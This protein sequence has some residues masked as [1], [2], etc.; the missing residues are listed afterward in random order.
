MH[1]QWVPV[2][3]D[4]E[5]ARRMQMAR[6]VIRAS[7]AAAFALL[8]VVAV[9]WVIT[10]HLSSYYTAAV[11]LV[12]IL[13]SGISL[14][15]LRRQRLNLAI[16]VYTTVL[17]LSLTAATYFLGGITGPVTIG[18]IMT[19]VLIGLTGGTRA[20]RYGGIIIGMIYLIMLLLEAMQVIHPLRV[21]A[22]VSWL[23]EGVL[24]QII[25]IVTAL[26]AGVFINQ[27]GRAF[28]A[29]RQRGFELA[30]AS[31]QAE[32]L[33]IAEREARE[34]E[35]RAALHIR[36]TMAGYVDY[37]SLVAAGEYTARVDVGELEEDVEGDRE[38]HA[39]GEYL[40]ATVDRLVALL[41]ET[42]AV[43]R[44]YTA[45]SWETV[46]EAGR[47]QPGFVYRGNQIAPETEWLPQMLQ[48][49]ERGAS[50][51]QGAG[52]A[53]PLIVNRQV[54]GAIGGQH[55]DGRLWTDEELA[56]IE[57]V[58]GQLAQ[59]IESL[60]LFDETQRRAARERV[61]R[62]VTA[63][64]RSSTDPETV[65]KALLREVGAVL[66]RATFVR[67]LAPGD[68]A[69]LTPSDAAAPDGN[70]AREGGL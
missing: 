40:N 36:E 61:L 63:R 10:P 13:F 70:A 47:V 31:R 45:Q 59:T 22:T 11:A 29:E 48:A 53:A 4:Q 43:Q 50:V 12:F 58:T 23:I 52:G 15:L 68:S 35:T 3:M 62:E 64:V 25:F 37:L 66:N 30:Q 51:A 26:A 18:F 28:T 20:L 19:A 49:V 34:R 16:G 39:L 32:E 42:Q 55:P 33:A 54:I 60:R 41:A 7:M 2:E 24:F 57:D 65:L 9:L 8:V 67:L 38:L 46:L 56:L 27:T 69:A 6:V 14:W 17:I 21:P 44:R 5:Q 1:T